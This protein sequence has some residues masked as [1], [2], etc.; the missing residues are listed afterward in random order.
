MPVLHV[1]AGPNGAGK[2]TYVAR[3]LEPVTHLPFVNADLIAAERSQLLAARRSFLTE[4]VF[5]HPSKLAL[6][7]EAIARGYLVHVHVIL[8]PVDVS[9]RRVA[10]RVR[11]G[12]HAVPERKI[13][14]RYARLWDLVARARVVADRTDFF[15]NST[16]RHP[17]RR[18][19]AYEHGRPIGE[20]DWPAWAPKEI[21][22][23]TP[24][25]GV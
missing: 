3:I 16:A 13:R 22:G 15:D 7:D 24:D 21:A 19:A 9:I 5:S 25:D 10:E 12:G 1:L 11:E 6:L 4:T 17:F 2:S 14:E 23:A 20:P 8:V 18:V